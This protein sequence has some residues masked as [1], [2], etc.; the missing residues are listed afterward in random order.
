[1]SQQFLVEITERPGD[2]RA[3]AS[4]MAEDATAASLVFLRTYAPTDAPFLAYVYRTS[5]NLSFAEYFW[6]RTDAEADLFEEGLLRLSDDEFAERVRHFF[7]AH[8]DYAERYL[9]HYFN[10]TSDEIPVPGFP[11]EMLAYIWFY[12]EYGEITVRPARR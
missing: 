5:I 12:S 7:G 1:M 8:S 4:V 9:E 10:A 6:I 11:P 2:S 3:F